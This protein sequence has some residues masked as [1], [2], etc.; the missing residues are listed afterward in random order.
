MAP[1][2]G[3]VMLTENNN[4]VKLVNMSEMI[5]GTEIIISNVQP[6]D[7]INLPSDAYYFRKKVFIY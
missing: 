2:S 6:L 1:F 7:S 3:Y 5:T 4:E